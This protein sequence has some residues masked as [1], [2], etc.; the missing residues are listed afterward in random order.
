[1]N[2]TIYTSDP[3]L[4]FADAVAVRG[5]RVLRVGTYASVQDLV[6]RGTRRL[7][8]EGKLVVPGF[9]DSHVHLI[10]GG[11]QMMRVELRS[12]K[13]QDDF[14]RKVKES[15]R[16]KRPGDWVLGGGWN[17]DIWGGDLPSASW[18]DDITRDNPVWLSRMDGHM[19][20]ANSLALEI[21]GIT[22]ITHDPV[23]G[24]IVKTIDGEPTGLLVD[25]AMKLVLSVIPEVSIHERRDALIRASKYA[26]MRGVT[27]VIDFGRYF[28]GASVDHVW[29][30][31]SD[32][33]RFADFSGK[34]FIRVCLFFPMQTWPRLVEL[35]KEKGRAFS[36]WIYLGGVKAFADGSLGSNSALFYEPYEDD[37]RNYG[38]QVSDFDWLLNATLASDNSGLQVAVHAIGD[39]ANDMVLN[40]FNTVAS[41]N[42]VRDR[43][44]RIEHAQ[45]LAPGS[46]ARF[47]QQRVIASVQ[48]DHL[49][50]DADSC[51]KKIGAT[52]AQKGS[53]LFKSLLAGSAK[54]AFGSDWPVADINPVGAIRTAL[55]RIPPGWEAAWI[56]TE[57]VGLHD[58]LNAYTLSA[59]YA[60]NLD[61]KLGSLSTGKYADFVVLNATWDEFVRQDGSTVVSSTYVNGVQ[62]YP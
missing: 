21:A 37:S 19:G 49:L 11:L 4:P 24:T 15:I 45:H 31:F 47:G 50:D 20:L 10:F 32:V 46:A 36:Q 42:G 62:A 30:D 61:D 2:G 59:A 27:T 1:M 6:G 18:I 54:V 22:N 29:Q 60:C 51:V 28:P 48:P 3:A 41:S 52:R 25:S 44:F 13:R 38:L 58:A 23:G 57:C 56:A 55:T 14:V 34:M 53:Y 8:L 16:D 5:G 35:F 12:V 26:L 7:D 40:L 17:N 9:I 43:R 39:K 33:Y